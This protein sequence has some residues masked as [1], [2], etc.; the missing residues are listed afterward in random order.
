MA[1]RQLMAK[2][3]SLCPQRFYDDCKALNLAGLPL[4]CEP[5][6]DEERAKLE[7]ALRWA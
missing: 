6:D 7:E 4:R 2:Q 3:C 1:S 5:I